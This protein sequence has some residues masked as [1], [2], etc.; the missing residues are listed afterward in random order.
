MPPKSP[1][2]EDSWEAN[3]GDDAYYLSYMDITSP[4]PKFTQE[5]LM[6]SLLYTYTKFITDVPSATDNRI[7]P[8]CC[9]TDKKVLQEI[10]KALSSYNLKQKIT[11]L[12]SL[13][14]FDRQRTPADPLQRRDY[15]LC[16]AVWASKYDKLERRQPIPSDTYI[17]FPR[18]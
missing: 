5:K 11:L 3:L 6:D 1:K 16:Q 4:D 8:P 12:K 15:R 2:C 10:S 14:Q 18:R 7:W 9:S 17:S 13:D